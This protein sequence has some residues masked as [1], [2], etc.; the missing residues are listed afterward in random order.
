MDRVV[1]GYWDPLF[2]YKEKPAL[3]FCSFNLQEMYKVSKQIEDPVLDFKYKLDKEEVDEAKEFFKGKKSGYGI[4]SSIKENG[5]P[6]L[7]TLA[8]AET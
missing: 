5:F 6:M 7:M 1:N 2:Y 3:F 4:V 8:S